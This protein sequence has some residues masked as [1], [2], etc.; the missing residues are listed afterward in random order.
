MNKWLLLVLYKDG[1]TFVFHQAFDLIFDYE[2]DK[3]M[4]K[5]KI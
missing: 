5:G 4:T 1:V 2:N 3:K